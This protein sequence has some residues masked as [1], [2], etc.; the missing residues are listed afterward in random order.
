[1][2]ALLDEKLLTITEAAK[3]FPGRDGGTITVQSLRRWIAKGAHCNG[4]RVKLEA[5]RVGGQ[6]RTSEEAIARFL[7]GLNAHAV[8]ADPAPTPRQATKAAER[9]GRELARR[10]L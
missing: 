3:R 7:A 10:G 8:P 4:V 1:M 6:W 2:P 5:Q 9:A